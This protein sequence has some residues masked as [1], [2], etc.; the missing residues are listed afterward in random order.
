MKI[1]IASKQNKKCLNYADGLSKKL[2]KHEIVFDIQTGKALSK[3]SEEIERF[4]GDIA[5]T[6]GGDGTFLRVAHQTHVPI[7][8]IRAEG[9]G[10]L[11]STSFDEFVKKNIKKF[12]D[13][14]ITKVSTLS[15]KNGIKAPRAIN[16]IFIA[17]DRK[18]TDIRFTI[19]E[20]EF[21]FIGDGIIF[22]TP[23]GSTGHAMSLGGPFIGWDADVICIVPVAP[24]NSKIRPMIVPSD[25]KIAVKVSS[26]V[27]IVDGFWKK[28]FAGRNFVIEKG[29]PVKIITLEDDCYKKF[30]E[31]FLD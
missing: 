30:R 18:I 11:C 14:E 19:D 16:E 21:G 9:V 8:P 22:S 31:K 28:P 20:T 3:T 27:V 26:G 10:Y 2:R 25:K 6:I 17:N 29:E 24:F 15:I 4:D 13:Y 12:D 5:I 23:L 7:L 1:L